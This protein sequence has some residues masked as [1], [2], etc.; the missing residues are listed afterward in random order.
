MKK[1]LLFG[2]TS[3]TLGGAERV[4]VDIVN[5][6]CDKYEITIF[7]IYPKGELEKE[8]DKK[9][10]LISLY[11]FSYSELSKLN[12]KIIAPLKVLFFKKIIYKNKIKNDYDVE[13]AFLEG[14]ITR[15]FSVKNKDTKKLVWIHNDISNVFGNDIKARLKRIMDKKIYLKYNKLIF[16]S[17]DNLEK[18]NE[19]YPK[20]KETEKEVI[21]N[22]LDKE[23]II[24]K[25]NE[26]ME[27]FEFKKDSLNFL[28]VARLVKQKGIDRMIKV[29]SKL[30]EEGKIHNFYVIGDGP[31]KENLLQMINKYKVEDTFHLLGK[32]ENPYPYIKYSD[33]FCL[34]SNFEGYGMVLEEAKILN[35]PIIITNTAAR[36]AVVNYDNKMILENS[37][38]GIYEGIKKKI[39]QNDIEQ[40]NGNK[41]YTNEKNLEKIIKIIEE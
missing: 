19:F 18:F 20:L 13:I 36:E 10:K 11:N 14:P 39:E 38:K 37:E 7:T 12:Q 3:L 9:I 25:A 29:H 21:Y 23:A 35:K 28:S 6:L 40:A 5:K 41:I 24:K 32:K 16:V 1:K 22:Y 30:I 4:L 2:I 27:E 34:L 17:E 33:Y 15:L 31:E 8:L 26:K